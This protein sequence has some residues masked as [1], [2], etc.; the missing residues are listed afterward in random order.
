MEN[1]NINLLLIIS[2][3]I[4][5]ASSVAF[6]LVKFIQS[7]NQELPSY[8]IGIFGCIF[9][10]LGIAYSQNI[11]I[12]NFDWALMGTYIVIPLV[13]IGIFIVV[14]MLERKNKT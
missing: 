3:N 10:M 2:M 6:I 4:I 13:I 5:Y 12:K 1:L 7:G 8:S 11:T 14:K 9:A